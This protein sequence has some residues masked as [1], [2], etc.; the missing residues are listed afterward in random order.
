MP[1]FE[2]LFAVGEVIVVSAKPSNVT[3][4]F[5]VLQCFRVVNRYT[6]IF[7]SQKPMC[8]LSS[9]SS[10]KVSLSRPRQPLAITEIVPEQQTVS[11]R[12]VHLTFP[13]PKSLVRTRATQLTMQLQL[14]TGDRPA[15][16]GNAS[17]PLSK[18]VYNVC[19][20]GLSWFIL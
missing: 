12:F 13:L 1:T 15:L 8:E 9:K 5:E 3:L 18:C 16:C 17:K 14:C 10:Y 4:Q 7:L 2:S 20:S 19:T 11:D 6:D